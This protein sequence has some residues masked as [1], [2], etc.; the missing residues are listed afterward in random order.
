M[1][2]L[3]SFS[4]FS[5]LDIR[6]GEVEEA[7]EVAGSEKLVKLEVD[8]GPEIGTKTIFAGIKEWYEHASLIGRK[9]AFVVNLEPKKFVIDEEEHVSEGMLIAADREGKAVLY[10][11]DQD[12][13]PGVRLK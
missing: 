12:L 7:N 4:D 2:N 6:V 3:V 1:K 8:F 11:F 13:P 9:L 5:R 10:T